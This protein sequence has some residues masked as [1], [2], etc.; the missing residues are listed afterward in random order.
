[1]DNK[2]GA[3]SHRSQYSLIE[4]FLGMFLLC[5][6]SSSR[7]GDRQRRLWQMPPSSNTM[8]QSFRGGEEK[9]AR[10]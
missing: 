7:G 8:Q 6:K 5:A 1:M 3:E 9:A 4:H 2:T 10:P